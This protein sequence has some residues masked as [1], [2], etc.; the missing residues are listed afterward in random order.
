[1]LLPQLHQTYLLL[2]ARPP[3]R[4]VVREARARRSAVRRRLRGLLRVPARRTPLGV[5]HA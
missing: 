3:E 5:S 4:A 2:D 1:M